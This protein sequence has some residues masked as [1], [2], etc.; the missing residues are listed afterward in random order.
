[1]YITARTLDDLL[2]DV[3]SKL[4]K[5]KNTINP[6]RGKAT[7]IPTVLLQIRNPRARHSLSETKGRLSSCLGELLWYLA[8]SKDL[9]FIA[10]YLSHYRDESD[11]G[12]TV[13][14]AYGPRLF[15]M[16]GINQIEN[17][18]KLLRK[19]PYTRRAVIQLFDATDI[20]SNHKEIP[21]TCTLQFLIR[22]RRLYMFTNMRSNDAFWGLP[23]DAFAFTMLQ[24]IMAR[25]LGIELGTYDHAV[26]SLHLYERHRKNAEQ[27]LKEG[28][29]ST[30][31][32]PP[33]PVGNP[34]R[35]IRK[36]LNA[37]RLIRGNRKVSIDRLRLDP[38]WADL[39][40][41]LQ[42]YWHFSRGEEA[43][44]GELKRKMS[45]RNFDGYVED[46]RNRLL[47][48][49]LKSGKR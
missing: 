46:L 4:A 2:H 32:M 48:R 44:I 24:E 31:P 6:T 14:G 7:E 27:Y 25:T 12:R 35:S 39:V 33:M 40:R 47:E 15:S 19:N 22:R 36:V 17:V 16:R 10:Y 38:Y 34:W 42:I 20:S 29:Q 5:S 28:W 8:G 41:L 21:C 30:A 1:M 23:H 26:G 3:L 11:D 18:L 43:P 45:V 9:K 49:K 13:Y 37:E